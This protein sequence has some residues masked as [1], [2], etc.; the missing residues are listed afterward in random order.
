MFENLNLSLKP[1]GRE[2]SHFLG[3]DFLIIA[4]PCSI[5]SEEQIF[6]AAAL[7]ARAGGDMLRGG[8]F[9]PRTSPYSFQGLGLPG[10]KL[11]KEAGDAYGLPT[12]TEVMDTRDLEAVE[13]SADIIQ[14]GARNMQNF[15]LLKEAGKIRKP[16]LLKRGLCATLEEW[17]CSA[18]YILSGGNSRVILCERGIRS[19]DTYLRNSFD[20]GGIS[21]LKE[22]TG[23]P[24]IADPSHACG[25]KT[26]ITPLSMSAV[27]GGCDGIM[28]E[29]HPHPEAALSDAGQALTPGELKIAIHKI[30]QTVSFRNT[31]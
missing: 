23:L 6:E 7:V 27:M 13:R 16:V 10:L 22:L 17:L 4:G 28:I 21:A 19:F 24:V 29:M 1:P 12:I 8:A 20:I 18:E 9:K 3:K 2:T 5:E 11:L 15:A 14:I 26:L 31:L 25:R 30:R